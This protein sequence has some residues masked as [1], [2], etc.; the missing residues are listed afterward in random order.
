M[1]W[2]GDVLRKC[3]AEVYSSVMPTP[4]VN[5]LADVGRLIRGINWVVPSRCTGLPLVVMA[6]SLEVCGTRTLGLVGRCGFPEVACAAVG[7]AIGVVVLDRGLAVGLG[8][9]EVLRVEAV[10]LGDVWAELVLVR[11]YPGENSVK[12]GSKRVPE[13]ELTA[14]ALVASVDS[15]SGF[16]SFDSGMIFS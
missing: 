12:A 14:A 3:E 13:V 15:S 9:G 2:E 16:G 6:P 7:P 8:G 11:E 1:V 4:V 5:S 10:T